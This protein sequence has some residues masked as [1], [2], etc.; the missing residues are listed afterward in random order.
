MASRST[1]DSSI[2][3]SCAIVP[4]LCALNKRKIEV[5]PIGEGPH[6]API[7]RANGFRAS[8]LARRN[9]DF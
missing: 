4:C 1:N 8:K 3:V 2:V 5:P 9:V 7:K 6:V